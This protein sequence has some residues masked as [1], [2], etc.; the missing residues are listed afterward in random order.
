MKNEFDVINKNGLILNGD[1]TPG[2]KKDIGIIGDTKSVINHL[3]YTTANLMIDAAD[4]A[5]APV[6]IDILT[7]KETNLLVDPGEQAR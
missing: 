7:H 3:E 4:L 5:V 1:G 2:V 6:F